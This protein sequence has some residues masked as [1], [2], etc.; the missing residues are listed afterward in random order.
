[1]ETR[2]SKEGLLEGTA[3]FASAGVDKTLLKWN[4]KYVLL[5]FILVCVFKYRARIILKKKRFYGTKDQG[6]LDR[7]DTLVLTRT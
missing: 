4:K 6:H 7:L 1:M 3:G 5:C 2:S